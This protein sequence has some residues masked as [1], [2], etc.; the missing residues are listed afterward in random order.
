MQT[1]SNLNKR[2]YGFD[3][4]RVICMCSVLYTHNEISLKYVNQYLNENAPYLHWMDVVCYQLRTCAVPTF[5]LISLLLFV[6]KKRTFQDLKNRIATLVYLFLFWSVASILVS[7]ARPRDG[8]V[9]WLLFFY[10]GGYSI[11]YFINN[12]IL[13]TLLAYWAATLKRVHVWVMLLLSITTSFVIFVWITSN[14][15]WV[16][17]LDGWRPTAYLLMPFA[18]VILKPYLMDGGCPRETKWKIV[19]GLGVLAVL[20]AIIEWRFHAPYDL[21]GQYRKWLP[22]HS[23]ISNQLTAII[24]VI[25]ASEIRAVP[26]KI[27]RLLSANSLGIYCSHWI[28]MWP[29]VY[30]CDRHLTRISPLL[31]FGLSYILVLLASLLATEFIRRCQQRRIV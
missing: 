16:H 21:V 11:F 6:S 20:F 5:M 31:S 1:D 18:A 14:N 24:F 13:C 15:S 23:R 27:I 26:G 28:I 9:E 4:L 25:L 3:Y 30:F 22:W 8:I 10:T 19:L 7:R 29:I 17:L 12:L 2:L